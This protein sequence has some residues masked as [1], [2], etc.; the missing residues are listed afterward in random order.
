M[1]KYD[2][3]FTGLA[4]GILA[5]ALVFVV[6]TKIHDPQLNLVDAVKRLMDSGVI[7]YYLSLCAIANLILFFLFL[8]VNAE[9][10]ARG[11]LGAT[12]IY[13]FTILILKLV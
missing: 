11:V 12:I 10:A 3:L 13:A 9:H 6:Y 8:R 7:S 2:T 5:P 1:K 4:A